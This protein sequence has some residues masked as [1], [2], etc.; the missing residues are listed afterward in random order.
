MIFGFLPPLLHSLLGLYAVLFCLG[1][2]SGPLWP[3]IQNFCIDEIPE[4]PTTMLILLPCIGV[5][6]CGFFTWLMGNLGDVIGLRSSLLLVPGCYM[7]LLFF[8]LWEKK[9][10]R[11]TIR[12]GLALSNRG[13]GAVTGVAISCSN[14]ENET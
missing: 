13:K 7:L 9:V 2:T 12:N 6:G 1:L 11:R 3:S 14:G 8:I 10:S 5:P 4:D